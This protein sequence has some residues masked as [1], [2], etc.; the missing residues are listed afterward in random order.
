MNSIFMLQKPELSLIPVVI[1]YFFRQQ[2]FN[3]K[4]LVFLTSLELKVM[5][6]TIAVKS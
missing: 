4:P 6:I 3:L 2:D 1:F 5:L